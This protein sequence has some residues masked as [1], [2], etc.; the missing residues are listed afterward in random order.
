M[1]PAGAFPR[2]GQPR[3]PK[4]VQLQLIPQLTSH[5]AGA[6]LPGPVQR[7]LLQA[8]LD[9]ITGR[10]LRH[11]PSGRIERQLPRLPQHR[12]EYFGRFGP[13]DLLTIIDFSEIQ[14]MPLHP[15]A[16]RL[17]LFSDAPRAMI[18]PVLEPVMTMQIRL[19]HA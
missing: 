3:P 11:L 7:K 16:A 19:G 9:S 6:P 8:H 12:I 18:L 13:G 2:I 14:Q 15:A 1:T 5:P 17:D 4:L 10:V